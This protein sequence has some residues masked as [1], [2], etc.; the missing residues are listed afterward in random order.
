MILTGGFENSTSKLASEYSGIDRQQVTK[1]K[2]K[3][4]VTSCLSIKVSVRE[5]APLLQGRHAHACGAYHLG[6]VQVKYEI[7]R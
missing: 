1:I 2:K 4:S 6:E 3:I 7:S 5:L